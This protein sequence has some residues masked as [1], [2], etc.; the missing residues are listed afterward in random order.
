MKKM[1]HQKLLASGW[2]YPDCNPVQLT[3]EP[4]AI[5][6]EGSAS[7]RQQVSSLL[8]MSVYENKH[9]K[10]IVTPNTQSPFWVS[11]HLFETHG[12][13]PENIDSPAG[14]PV[15]RI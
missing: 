8:L 15:S 12:R 7:G 10:M 3:P 11:Q 14:F 1:K 9:S 13:L 2:Q 6:T 5:T 4:A